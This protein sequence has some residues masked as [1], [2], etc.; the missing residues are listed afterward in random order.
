MSG[1]KRSF[2]MNWDFYGDNSV[3]NCWRWCVSK[4][5]NKDEWWISGYLITE[6]IWALNCCG[7]SIPDGAEG[8]SIFAR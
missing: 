1:L 5:Y 7:F 4:W 3:L 2:K 6:D 8:K